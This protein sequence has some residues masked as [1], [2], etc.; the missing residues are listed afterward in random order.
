MRATAFLAVFSFGWLAGWLGGWCCLER[1]CV[2]IWLAGWVGGAAWSAPGFPSAACRPNN[3]L[4]G[5]VK[6]LGWIIRRPDGDFP[7][8]LQLC[9]PMTSPRARAQ[10]HPR[11]LPAA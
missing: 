9:D 8:M 2:F 3:G 11:G 4:R 7:T 10:P 1:A 5:R 6:I